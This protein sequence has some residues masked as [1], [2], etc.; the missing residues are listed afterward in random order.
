MSSDSGVITRDDTAYPFLLREIHTPPQQLYFRGDITLLERTNMLAVVGS[1]NATPYGAE[2]VAKLL[3]PCIE[4]GITIASGMAYGIDTLAHR[5]SVTVK[6]PTIA[7]LGAGVDDASLYPRENKNLAHEILH[8]GGLIISEYKPG[9]PPY[10]SHFP[11]RN[12]IVAGITY[13]TLVIQA[14]LRS[15]SLI[16]ARLAMESNREVL[17]VPGPITDPASEGTNMLIRDGAT[18]ILNATD[19]LSIFEGK[20]T[21]ATQQQNVRAGEKT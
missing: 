3:P 4:A 18:P 21:L 10:A 1:R 12:R 9:T 16:T 8:Y 15:G 2:A 14:A 17:A 7:V 20:R 5:A 6:A 19:I 11:A 13:A